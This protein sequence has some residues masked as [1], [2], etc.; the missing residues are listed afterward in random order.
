MRRGDHTDDVGRA[1]IP[2]SHRIGAA[3]FGRRPAQ[4]EAGDGARPD[5]P[6]RRSLKTGTLMIVVA[7]GFAFLSAIVSLVA[8]DPPARDPDPVAAI[9]LRGSLPLDPDAPGAQAATPR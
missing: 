1:A 7:T 2:V 6:A 3:P 4:A 9:G 8:K 5:A